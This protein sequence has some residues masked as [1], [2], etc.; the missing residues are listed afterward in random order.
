MSADLISIIVPVYNIDSYIS[1]CMDS[2]VNQSYHDLEIIVI[3]DGSTDNSLEIISK[4]AADDSRII[5]IDQKNL[6][7]SAARNAGIKIAHG[8]F[9]MFVD[10]DDWIDTKTCEQALARIKSQEIDLV[11]WSYTREYPE[12]ATLEKNL[13]SED[14]LF[15]EV[16]CINLHRRLFGLYGVQLKNPEHADSLVTVWGKLYRTKVI[17]DNNL[18]F[19]D[20]K[21]IGTAEDALFNIYYFNY[22]ERAFYIHY[23]YYHYRK[24]VPASL[25]GQYKPSLLQ[26][27]LTLF[28]YMSSLLISLNLD[29][30][31]E[32]ALNN[33]IA[34]SVVG[35]GLNECHSPYPI[36]QQV[37]SLALILNDNKINAALKRLNIRGMPIYW[38]FFFFCAKCRYNTLVWLLLQIINKILLRRF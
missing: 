8:E 18:L 38:K 16:E 28:D 23:H 6:G 2:I 30:T 7:V 4:Y 33:R 11:F 13:F 17:K 25:T 9:L 34:M 19:I 31:F 1:R 27:W 20:T 37:R 22:I 35:L 29:K 24:N 5:V 12:G 15:N 36:R 10:G 14:Q 21:K 26:Q 32:E 3:N